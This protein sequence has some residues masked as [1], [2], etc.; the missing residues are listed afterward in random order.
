MTACEK[1]SQFGE[2]TNAGR[3]G[4]KSR[5]GTG[6]ASL[7]LMVSEAELRRIEEV[8]WKCLLRSLVLEQQGREVDKIVAP[9]HPTVHARSPDFRK[10]D[11]LGNEPLLEFAVH[12]ADNRILFSAGNPEQV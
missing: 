4:G 8:A 11:L 6:V 12:L 1:L 3:A 7:T 9:D 2:T 10:L 5:R